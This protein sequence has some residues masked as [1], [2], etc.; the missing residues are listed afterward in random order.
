[1]LMLLPG[2]RGGERRRSG[3]SKGEPEDVV[4][5]GNE[6]GLGVQGGQA[7]GL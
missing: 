2:S 7:R 3:V 5:A 6:A 4:V 1:M